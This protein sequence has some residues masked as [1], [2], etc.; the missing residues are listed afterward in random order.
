MITLFAP[1]MQLY[2][3]KIMWW[4]QET[5]NMQPGAI[6]PLAMLFNEYVSY[7]KLCHIKN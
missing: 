5:V 6:V 2:N 3:Y 1:T 7:S 4:V